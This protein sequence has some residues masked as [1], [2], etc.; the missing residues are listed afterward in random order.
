MNVCKCVYV[1][2]DIFNKYH[3]V[4]GNLVGDEIL[5]ISPENFSSG[6]SEETRFCYSSLKIYSCYE[7]FRK[8][9]IFFRFDQIILYLSWEE[10]ANCPKHFR[11]CSFSKK[12]GLVK[13]LISFCVKPSEKCMRSNFKI[14]SLILTKK[15]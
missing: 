15:N 10:T 2:N 14:I 12:L 6:G 13:S 8:R 1:P 5:I 9:S 3:L 11:L 4:S 7:F